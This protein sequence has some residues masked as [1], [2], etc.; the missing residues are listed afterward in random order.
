MRVERNG[1]HV[2]LLMSAADGAAFT[3]TATFADSTAVRP[4]TFA[5]AADTDAFLTETGR[6]FSYLGC[7]VTRT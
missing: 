6:S 5:T 2:A 1:G 3:V 4:Y 7:D